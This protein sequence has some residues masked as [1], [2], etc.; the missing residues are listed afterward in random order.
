M[1]LAACADLVRRGDADRWL[2]LSTVSVAARERLLP[3]Y[4]FNL[5]V[6][7]APWISSEP[8]IGQMRLQWWRD[9]LQE[10]AEGARPRRHEVVSPLADVLTPEAAAEL[11]TLVLMRHRDLE[12]APFAD[13][14]AL[15]HYLEETGGRLVLCA[16]TILG[17]RHDGLADAAYAG[18]LASYLRAVAELRARGRQPLPDARPETLEALA[19]AGLARWQAARRASVDRKAIPAL[20]GLWRTPAILGLAARDPL[21]IL[22]G[23]LDTSP[24]RRHLTLVGCRLRGGW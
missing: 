15:Q 18:A 10:I 3:L 7:R 1:S 13:A 11:D 12:I 5:E 22:Q 23:G 19:R 16:G 2:S 4:A 14:A 20:R 9:A 24:A 21:R 17:A 6:A 8:M